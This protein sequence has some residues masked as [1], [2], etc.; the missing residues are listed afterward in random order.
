MDFGSL[1]RKDERGPK[2]TTTATAHLK[3]F[4][5]DNEK[6]PRWTF[7]IVCPWQVL[8]EIRGTQVHHLGS[9]RGVGIGPTLIGAAVGRDSKFW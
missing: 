8:V 9:S 2:W 3:N 6:I 4:N 5:L 1:G 7:R